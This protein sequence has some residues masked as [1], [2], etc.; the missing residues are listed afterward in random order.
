MDESVVK[1]ATCVTL[2]PECKKILKANA[3]KR[4]M[5][6]SALIE[7]AVREIVERWSR[8]AVVLS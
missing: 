2:T 1:V 5:S 8:E 6:Q 3:S 4:G 7:L